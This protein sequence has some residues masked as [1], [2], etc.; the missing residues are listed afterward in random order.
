MRSNISHWQKIWC[1]VLFTRFYQFMS[2]V[3]TNTQVS[4]FLLI[5][6]NFTTILYE[7][8]CVEGSF[9][10]GFYDNWRWKFWYAGGYNTSVSNSINSC[11]KQA[12][13]WSGSVFGFVPTGLMLSS[14]IG[15]ICTK[16]FWSFIEKTSVKQE[17]NL[18]W[19]HIFRWSV[20]IRCPPIK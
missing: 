9:F 2:R 6:L 11:H 20:Q 16:Y 14:G 18:K 5:C 10:F 8:L 4:C 7:T 3:K 17:S 12:W 1:H 19:V 13:C 15:A